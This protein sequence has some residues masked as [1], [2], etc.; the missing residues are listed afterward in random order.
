MKSDIYSGVSRIT[1]L[2]A[3]LLLSACGG[4]TAAVES[5]PHA[6][7]LDG[8]PD[9]ARCA[10]YTVW[11]N[12][13]TQAGRRIPLNIVVL[14]ALA[15][16]RAP[17]P[18]IVL[19]GGPG[20]AAT[21]LIGVFVRNRELRTRRDIVFIDQ[22]GTG[23]SNPLDCDLYGH[24]SGPQRILA[25]PFPVDAVR[26]CRQKLSLVA[27]LAQY[28]TAAAVDDVD[29]VRRWLGYD[30]V[31]LWGGSYGT[32]AAQVYL[33]R[34]GEHVRSAVLVGVL[35]VDEL[36]PLHQA[37]TA[38]RAVQ[39]L[40]DRNRQYP[41]LEREFRSVFDP[42]NPA[43]LGLAE[44]LRHALYTDD[45][46][47]FP[48]LIHRAATGDR[49]PLEQRAIDA[50]TAISALATGLNLSVTCAEDLP[51]LDDATIARETDG[52]FLGDLRVQRQRAAC[53]EWVRG[54]VPPDVHE[55]VRSAVPVL[56]LSGGRDP[57]TPPSFAEHV[58][59]T[60]TNSRHVV[61]PESAHGN[62]GDCGR[63][64]LA[65]FIASADPAALNT[66]CAQVK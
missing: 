38:Q 25:G 48:A 37:A 29:D 39:I 4:R 56:L 9:P 3:F 66:S 20:Q 43:T 15:T 18:L 30:Q 34:H 42:A 12:R 5:K 36:V 62:L 35:P 13:E 54:A 47:S 14:P 27:D 64:L 1:P 46:A 8:I 59:T 17:D 58:A 23:R 60:L 53:R 41:N 7:S 63:R 24:L 65:A 57:V 21:E 45:G 10:T 19:A 16:P 40:F 44:G 28:T 61:F 22:R 32:R 50:E 49:G 55:P 33:R 6:C 52:T 2:A 31:N 11:E 26:K 51:F